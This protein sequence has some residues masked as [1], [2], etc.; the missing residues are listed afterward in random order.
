M[1]KGKSHPIIPTFNR[2][3]TFRERAACIEQI[4]RRID[5]VYTTAEF[6]SRHIYWMLALGNFVVG[7][8]I[9]MLVMGYRRW[10]SRRN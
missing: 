2:H 8:V 1:A 10:A 3:V 7:A 9:E 6:A 4:L 5:R